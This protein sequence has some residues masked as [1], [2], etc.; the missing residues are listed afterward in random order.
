MLKVIIGYEND[1]ENK[2][3]EFVSCHKCGDISFAVADNRYVAFINY[4]E[5]HKTSATE[6]YENSDNMTMEEILHDAC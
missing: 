4:K 2:V 5:T 3:N 1:F 6:Y